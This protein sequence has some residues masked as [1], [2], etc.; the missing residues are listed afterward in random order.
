MLSVSIVVAFCLASQVQA[1]AAGHMSG[2]IQIPGHPQGSTE[3]PP[4]LLE[5][6]PQLP[7]LNLMVS[8]AD[9]FPEIPAALIRQWVGHELGGELEKFMA[10]IHDEFGPVPDANP[11]DATR[12]DTGAAGSSA[13]AGGSDAAGA[14]PGPDA[15]RG[16]KR[17]GQ[18][19]PPTGKRAKVDRTKV[20]PTADPQCVQYALTL[21]CGTSGTK[22]FSIVFNMF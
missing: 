13:G 7:K 10:A 15:G 17:K 14:N 1:L 22:L 21:C 3:C 20:L 9:L 11:S 12:S 6:E 4:D 2:T 5:A 19:T 18:G 8:R 16:S